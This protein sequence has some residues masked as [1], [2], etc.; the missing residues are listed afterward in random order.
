VRR[1][2]TVVAVVALLALV[3]A[4]AGAKKHHRHKKPSGV[5][6][7][8]RDAT[9]PGACA[10]P[11]PPEPVYTGAVTIEVRRAADGMLVKSQAIS[12]GQFRLRVKP[13]T[14]DVA[15]V[16]PAPTPQPQPC[17][18]EQLCPLSGGAQPAAIVA[19][20]MTGETQRVDVRKRRFTY[21]ELHVRNTCIA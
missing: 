17:P 6:G 8:V 12:N 19:P 9:C 1:V 7:V 11:P 5:T 20:C 15:S 18:P 16:P 13:G 4:P 2:S 14:Y 10:E 3:V 21:V